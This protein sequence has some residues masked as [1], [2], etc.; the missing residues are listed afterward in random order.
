MMPEQATLPLTLQVT[1]TFQA[2]RERVFRAWTEPEQLKG[3]FRPDPSYTT[4]IVEVDLRVGGRYRLGMQQAGTEPHIV[5]GEFREIQA[6]ERL[7]FTWRWEG[8]DSDPESLVTLDFHD[9][10][11]AT[12]VVLSHENFVNEEV[13]DKHQQGWDGCLAQLAALL[14]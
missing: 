4:P 8:D 12:E 11:A 1:R 5:G 9:R 10:G 3:W 2:T 7:V 13:R 6:P 14:G